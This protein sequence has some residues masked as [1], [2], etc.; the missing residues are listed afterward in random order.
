[1]DRR[2]FVAALLAGVTASAFP[3][4]AQTTSATHWRVLESEGFDAIA[5]L[6]ALSGRDIYRTHYAADADAFGA[7]LGQPVVDEIKAL[8]A[9]AEPKVGLLW[10]SLCTFLS[11]ADISTIDKVIAALGDPERI[12]RPAYQASQYWDA[13]DWAWFTGAAPRVARVF[14]A[15]QTAGFAAFRKER[16]GGL[17]ARAAD[18]QRGLASY[19]VIKWQKKLTGRDFKPE[20]AI[21]LLQFSKPHGVKVQGQAFLQ[22]ADYDVATTV[23]IA[24]HEMLHP[25]VPMDGATA[26]AALALLG[27]DPLIPRIARD[28]DPKWGYTTVEGLFNEDLT[29]ALDQLISEGLGVA[30]NP[31]DRWR[32]ADDGI[33]VLAGAFYGLLREDHWQDTGGPIERWLADA[34]QRGRLAPGNLHAVAARVLERPAG[35]LWPLPKT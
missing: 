15:M 25:P 4:R 9:D 10:P 2:T 19:D 7:K 23:R 30:R 27:K 34:I 22:S 26:K 24:A 32:K 8:W 12:V 20:I 29:Q 11:G 17:A 18:I 28:H 6:G 35:S 5:F 1:M 31:A 3:L 21:Y 16:T 13:K 33:H 14:E